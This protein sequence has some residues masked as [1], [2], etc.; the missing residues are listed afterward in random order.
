MRIAGAAVVQKGVGMS[1]HFSGP[2]LKPPMEDGR[3]DFTDLFAFQSPSDPDRCV[4]IMDMNPFAPSMGEGL[5]PD[6]VYRINIDNDGD[7]R[8]D[9][10]FNV[11][12]S[13]PDDQGRQRATVRLATGEKARDPQPLGETIVEGA[14]LSSGPES[15]VVKIGEYI[16]A[17]GLRSDPFVVDIDGFLDNFQWTGTDTMGDKNVY[18][19]A[20]EFPR[21][22]LGSDQTL[23]LWARISLITDDGIVSVDRGGQPTV[24]AIFN[25]EDA[26]EEY[27][28]GEPAEDRERYVD[29]FAEVL[30]HAGGY[31]KEDAV[32][33]AKSILPDVLWFDFSKPAVFPNGRVLNDHVIE[34]RLAILGNGQIPS[35]GLKP[36][37]DL[38]AEFPF[39]GPPHEAPGS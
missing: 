7:L 3:L 31:S 4:L 39:L 8:A 32:T 10:A 24:T 23:A 17:A 2:D 34:A 18:S 33:A 15:N 12:F 5:H 37:E 38:L 21:E 22:I 28:R 30:E 35:D 20:L 16:F 36:H 26:K 27:N 1:N 19:I 14:E 11:T 25:P 6:A 9:V 13:A 29:R